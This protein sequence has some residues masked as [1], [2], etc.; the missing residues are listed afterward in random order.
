V[1]IYSPGAFKKKGGNSCMLYRF[2]HHE[3]KVGVDTYVSE[4]AIVIGDVRIGDECYIG[5]GAILRGDY[6]TIEIGRESAVEE[7]AVL[8]APPQ[9]TCRLGSRVTVGHGA[10]VHSRDIG[11]DAVI[12]MGAVVSIRA[13]IGRRSIVAEGAVVP[14][15]KEFPGDVVIAG[16]PAKVLRAI[17]QK[18][19]DH[20]QW[21]KQLYIDLAKQYLHQGMQR[22]G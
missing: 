1:A 19:L 13:V 16:N 2:D 15:E 21:G 12:G 8:H 9:Q 7:G 20:W 10:I 22:V 6:G 18:D 3:P 5:H 17:S 11:R 4:T 14:M